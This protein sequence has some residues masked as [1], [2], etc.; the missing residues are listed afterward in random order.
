[1]STLLEPRPMPASRPPQP[2]GA[3]SATV[4][5]DAG[6]FTALAAV[7]GWPEIVDDDGSRGA[8]AVRPAPGARPATTGG[9]ELV[10]GQGPGSAAKTGA[11]SRKTR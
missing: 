3:R 6:E 9:S 10:R 2:P 5:P 4:D 11:R 7:T 8:G 1:M